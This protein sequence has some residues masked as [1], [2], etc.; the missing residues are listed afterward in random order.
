MIEEYKHIFS[1]KFR[2]ALIVLTRSQIDNRSTCTGEL[3]RF[4]STRISVSID[5]REVG[6]DFQHH[7]QWL[8]FL[9]VTDD[10]RAFTIPMQRLDCDDPAP[11]P[12]S[13]VDSV[14]KHVRE[15]LEKPKPKLPKAPNYD[16]G[17][18]QSF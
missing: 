13:I 8:E 6:V 9:I 7:G 14:L 11:T 12:E 4:L 3:L 16:L 1:D 5:D 15:T 2:D 10:L 17:I 18:R